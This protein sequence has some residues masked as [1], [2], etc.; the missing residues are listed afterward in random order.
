MVDGFVAANSR[1][2]R[3][4]NGGVIRRLPPS[5][6]TVAVVIGGG[7]GHYPAFGG[8]VGSG[9]AH[10]AVIGNIF[11][12]PSADQA[13][14]VA[15]ACHTGAGV[16]LIYGNY[17]GDVLNFDQAQERLHG[18]GI[19]CQTVVVTDD[20]ISAPLEESS[21][22]RGIAG[23]LAVFK[24]AGAAADQGRSLPEVTRVAVLANERCRSFGV[25]F[26]GCTLPGADGPLFHVAPGR[27]S[28]GMGVHGEPGVREQNLP[29]ADGLADL[30]VDTLLDER[31]HG[32]DDLST[33]RVAVVLNGLG[34][35]KYEELFIVYRRVAQRLAKAGVTVVDPEVGELVT[36][37]DM[38]GASLTLFWLNDELEVLW[39]APADSPGYRRTLVSSGEEP[40]TIDDEEAAAT[41]TPIRPSTDGSREASAMAVVMLRAAQ[42]ATEEHGTEF[43]LLDSVAGDGDHGMGMQR[44]TRAAAEAAGVAVAQ[45][46]GLHTTL[47]R[48][49]DAWVNGAGGA[50]GA[51]WGV[52]LRALAGELS[53]QSA[54]TGAALSRGITAAALAIGTTG[55]AQVGDKTMLDAIEP[56][57]LRFHEAI[58]AG[59]S[60]GNALSE[61]SQIARIAAIQTASL[62]PRIGRARTH[63][64]RSVGTPD[65]GAMSFAIIVGAVVEDCC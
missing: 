30:F 22:R 7:S 43:G 53:D 16:L 31:P 37:F 23:D 51:L 21:R 62:V 48:A 3:R 59:I 15:R 6:P 44:G 47:T 50:S 29:T 65:P 38:A 17:A 25:A 11:A 4:V 39:R 28:V 20:I 58:D 45:G 60:I 55:K 52:A 36:S 64:E 46:S 35:V 19:P 18:D 13:Y 26:G 34:S 24:V 1:W 33:A 49:A 56:F 42:R 63:G 41:E 12:S 14:S 57:A 40:T 54:P 10:G 27:M 9:M 8:L 61:A 2:V 32:I 5:A